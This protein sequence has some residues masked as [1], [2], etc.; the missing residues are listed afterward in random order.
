MIKACKLQHASE[1]SEQNT[2]HASQNHNYYLLRHHH[3]HELL[4]VDLAITINVRLTNHFINLLIRELLSEICHDVAQ[5]CGT[6][7]AVAIA[8]ENLEG[9]DELLFGVSVLHLA[10]HQR[11]EFW[12]VNCAVA[13]RIDLIDHVL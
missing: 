8:I 13:V 6:D 1:H 5:L 2:A 10:C 11:Q 3:L 9:L 7:E 12:E 4:I